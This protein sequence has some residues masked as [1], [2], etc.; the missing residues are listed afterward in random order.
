M[1]L[2]GINIYP[3]KSLQA[4]SL[5][6]A[7]VRERGLLHDRRMMLVAE[8]GT[9]ITQRGHPSLSL[10]NCEIVN[11]MLRVKDR[12]HRIIDIPIDSKPE[13]RQRVNVWSSELLAGHVSREA[14]AFFSEFLEMK[15]SLVRMDDKSHRNVVPIY[16]DNPVRVSF[17]DG[18]PF[19]L[20]GESSLEDLNQKLDL[21]VGMERFRPNFV[22]EGG[23][24][25]IED[26]WSDFKIGEVR[27]RSVKQCSR[28]IMTTV[29]DGQT[30][31][32]PLRTLAEY[33]KKGNNT[34]FGV[35][36]ISLSTGVVR[37]G[38]TIKIL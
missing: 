3:V 15:C 37:V 25:F 22:F 17:A 14:D 34:Y 29:Q 6:E 16:T 4:I 5:E 13:F 11:G 2:S 10:L 30:G 31:V 21:P 35:N 38:D 26:T 8:D 7:E 36:L 23:N 20:I 19:L 12:A 9:F 27:F 18:F 32:E 33:R 24:A 1:Q 28:C